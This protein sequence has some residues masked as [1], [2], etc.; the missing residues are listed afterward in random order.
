M[1]SGADW[2]VDVVLYCFGDGC[3]DE[4]GFLGP[5]GW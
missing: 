1:G 5:V 3:W 4:F 2:I